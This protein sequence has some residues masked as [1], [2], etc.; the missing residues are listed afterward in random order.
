MI[1]GR[2][3]MIADIQITFWTDHPSDTECLEEVFLYHTGKEKTLTGAKKCHDVIISS[4]KDKLNLSA[5]KPLM[6]EGY[7]NENV[8]VKW[9]NHVDE[10]ENIISVG[11]TILIRHQPQRSLTVCY[12]VETK[13]RFSKSYRPQL[14]NCI[15]FLLHNIAS[16]HGKYC[17]HASCMVKDGNAYLFLGKS[18]D[19]KSTISM[20]LGVAGW[21]YMGDD[22]VFI[23]LDENGEVIIDG[24][25]SK[26]KLFNEK[27]KMKNSIDVIK[28]QHFNYTYK[29]KLGAIFNL[30][31]THI[32]KE[33]VL[34]PAS[35]TEVFTWLMSAGNNIKIQY[36][37]RRWVDICE[38]ASSLPAHTLMF[39][40][41]EYFNPDILN[42]ALQ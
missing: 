15:F 39:A 33:S 7:I 6:W 29:K 34:L 8:P 41:K 1:T 11:D 2:N 35:Q 13:A 21:E 40:D 5:G 25:L 36:R 27:S 4:S 30:Q 26:A 32:C 16:M 18:G 31:R 42:A 14:T 19:G 12:L 20:L 10:D 17:I 24:F 37:Q 22:L 38:K 28:N 23:S 3:I 9:Y